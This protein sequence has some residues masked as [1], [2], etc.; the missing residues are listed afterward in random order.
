MELVLV[1]G[2]KLRGGPSAGEGTVWTRK[3]RFDKRV[4]GGINLH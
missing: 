2:A 4:I 1:R 3:N